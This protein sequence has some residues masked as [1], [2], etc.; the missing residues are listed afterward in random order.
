MNGKCSESSGTFELSNFIPSNSF[1]SNFFPSHPQLVLVNFFFASGVRL[2]PM[3]VV[4]VVVVGRRRIG[5]GALIL[6]SANEILRNLRGP[7]IGPTVFRCISISRSFFFSRHQ[8]K[9]ERKKRTDNE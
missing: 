1:E 7:K 8:K 2:V 9:K 4:D 6:S 5:S 3:A